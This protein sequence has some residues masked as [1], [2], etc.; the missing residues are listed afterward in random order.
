[1][2]ETTITVVG[3]LVADPVIRQTYAGS[4]VTTFRIAT[5]AR[6]NRP[7][8]GEFEDGPTSYYNIS[9]YKS[10]GANAA[11]SLHRGEPVVVTGALEVS[12]FDRQDG[13]KGSAADITAR[14]I[15]HDLSWVCP[16]SPRCPARAWKVGVPTRSSQ[17]SLRMPRW[18]ADASRRP[19]RAARTAPPCPTALWM[20]MGSSR[21]SAPRSR[22]EPPS[23]LREG[24]GIRG[25]GMGLASLC[26]M[27]EF[28][29]VMSRARKAH[30]D[31]VILDDVTLSFLPGAKIGVVGPNGAG[32]S[33]VLKIMAGLDQPSNG[34]ARLTP[35]YSVGI[36][37]QEPVLDEEKTVLGNV[38]EG[39]GEI[40][41]KL[42]RFNAI[43]AE[44]AEP[45]AD[46][47][48]PDDRDGH[49]QEEID[50]ADAWDLDSQL[51]QAMDALR[52]PPP[53]ADVTTLSGGERAASP[54]ASCSCRSLTCCCSTSP[55]TT[56]TPSRSSGSS[57]TSP[58]IPAPSS[59]SPTTAISWTTSPGGSSNSTGA[60]PTPTRATTPTYLEK[61]A[62]RPRSR[63][64]RTPNW[65]SGSP[66]NSSGCAPTP[67]RARPSPRPV[68]PV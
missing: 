31:K 27:P 39:A 35:G 32:K 10:L 2:N 51:E 23:R 59:P 53:D 54:S 41:A 25:C 48:A 64:R 9:A 42:D 29:Y 19:A 24:S 47:D 33:S 60:A 34:E 46:F 43:S 65:P 62:A 28:I 52:C 26:R 63:A 5:N 67:R 12:T 21:R 37:M 13:S 58:P 40:K 8:T 17:R 3:R 57:S 45:D 49:A 20:R 36:L 55:P 61:K 18:P 15:G 30:G 22:R 44:M 50:H 11:I 6:K 56:S 1:M 7:G 4:N 14:Q 66:K 38:E 16:A 68:W